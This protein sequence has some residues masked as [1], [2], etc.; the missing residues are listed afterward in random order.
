MHVPQ[1]G[2]V[3]VVAHAWLSSRDGIMSGFL[4]YFLSTL[5][6]MSNFGFSRAVPELMTSA[7][8]EWWLFI[9]LPFVVMVLPSIGIW[10]IYV[11]NPAVL[12]PP[13]PALPEGAAPLVSVVVAGRN[14]LETIGQCIRGALLSGYLN[15]EVIFVDDNSCAGNA[16]RGKRRERVRRRPGRDFGALGRRGLRRESGH[17]CRLCVSQRSDRVKQPSPI[18]NDRNARFD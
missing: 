15:L 10:M 14:E 2:R 1:H 9:V 16:W 5:D 7:L 3:Q 6:P 17:V 18:A 12:R 13:P 11:A 4:H 8:P